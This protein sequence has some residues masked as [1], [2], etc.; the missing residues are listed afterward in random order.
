ME[1]HE[2]LLMELVSSSY[3]KALKREAKTIEQSLIQR[4]TQPITSLSDLV[5][6]E[7]NASKLAGLRELFAHVEE[8]AENHALQL[9]NEKG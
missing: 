7:G 8:V 5:A 9:R 1:E 6:K 4:L 2:D 3:W